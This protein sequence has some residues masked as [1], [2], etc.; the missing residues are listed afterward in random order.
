MAEEIDFGVILPQWSEQATPEGIRRTAETAER[1]G[2]D[3]V[4]GGDHIVFPAEFPADAADWAEIDTPTYD[5]FTVLSY[6]SGATESIN[7]GTN[8]CVAPLRHPVH[9]AKLALSI[10]SL[11]EGRFE[12]GIAVGWL[13]NE[14][15]ILDVSFGNR[16]ELTDEFLELFDAVCAN[17]EVEFDGQYHSFQQAG[18]YP[19][20][21]EGDIPVWVGGRSGAAVRR[22]AEYGDGWTIGN[23]T[24]EELANEHNRLKQAW[25]DFDRDGAPALSHTHDTYVTQDRQSLP[26]G[27]TASPTA[28]TSEE[29]AEAIEE[30]ADAGAT[31]INLRLRGLSIDERVEQIERF[32]DEVIPML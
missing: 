17:G 25:D 31:R 4:W 3:S 19:R 22:V 15:D 18:F 14:Y 2:F 10:D 23:L 24:P 9:L 27:Y 5:I 28:G 29:V 20:P 12:L 16:G 32:S 11:S 30:Y 26:E 21:A 13:K 8:I 6:V 1:C 7:V